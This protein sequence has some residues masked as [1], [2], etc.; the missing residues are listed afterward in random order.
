MWDFTVDP[1]DGA[2]DGPEPS[3]RLLLGG[4]VGGLA[5]AIC[6]TPGERLKVILQANDKGFLWALRVL[7]QGGPASMY[8]GLSATIAREIPGTILFM[9]VLE[10]VSCYLREQQ[11][12]NRL[13]AVMGGSATAAF[14]WS[15]MVCPME[16]V[17]TVQQ[18]STTALLS[19]MQVGSQ[20]WRNTGFKG[21]F[22]GISPYLL[23]CVLIDGLQYTLADSAR[24]QLGIH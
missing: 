2:V 1:A 12:W 7:R 11:D 14:C 6:C 13:Q 24:Q 22:I 9:F 21:F 10:G 5:A 18:A 23:R 8:T 19:P 17:K 16:R 20:I 3:Q 4:A 15:F